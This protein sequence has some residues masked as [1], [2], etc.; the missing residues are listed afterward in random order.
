M[1]QASL[2]MMGSVLIPALGGIALTAVGLR[3]ARWA[4]PKK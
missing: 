1:I 4:A 3:A 2:L